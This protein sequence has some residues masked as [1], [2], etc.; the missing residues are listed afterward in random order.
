MPDRLSKATPSLPGEGSG[1]PADRHGIWRMR[2]LDGARDWAHRRRRNRRHH[3]GRQ[4]RPRRGLR[5]QAKKSASGS[6]VGAGDVWKPCWRAGR[7]ACAE[8]R[9]RHDRRLH[10]LRQ[11]FRRPRPGARCANQRSKTCPPDGTTRCRCA[12]ARPATASDSDHG[13][14]RGLLRPRVEPSGRPG[15]VSPLPRFAAAA[16]AA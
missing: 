16:P 4:A 15:W 8:R 12:C 3:Q 5:V 2:C 10:C 14:R 6:T 9:F 13:H 7:S 1:D 11:G